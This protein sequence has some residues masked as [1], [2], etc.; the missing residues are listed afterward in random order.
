MIEA[1]Q[2]SKLYGCFPAVSEVSFTLRPGEICGYLGPNGSGK[3]TTLKML[4]GLLKPACGHILFQGTDI[5]RQLIEYRRVLGCVP[6]EPHVYSYLTGLEYLQ[7][8]GRLRGIP[9][10]ALEEKTEQFLRA[11]SL[12]TD[13]YAPISAYS[14]GMRQKILIA[15][16]LLHDPKVILLDEPFSGLDVTSSLRGPAAW[17]LQDS[18]H[19]FLSARKG[20]REGDVAVLLDGL[21]PLCFLDGGAGSLA[22]ARAGAVRS[23][24]VCGGGSPGGAGCPAAPAGTALLR[25]G[26]RRRARPRGADPGP[27]GG[28]HAGVRSGRGRFRLAPWR[29]RCAREALQLLLPRVSA[30]VRRRTASTALSFSPAVSALTWIS[31]GRSRARTVIR[32]PRGIDTVWGR[33]SR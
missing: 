8:V 22:V 2:L 18:L 30:S 6:E 28:A 13:R 32:W 20:Q 26:L 23:V 33:S 17:F 9:E 4:T 3:T 25:V 14:K 10:K 19:L 27:A 15:A 29:A 31:V 5:Q 16:A 11:L 7:L 21:Q 24:R 12:W 1:R